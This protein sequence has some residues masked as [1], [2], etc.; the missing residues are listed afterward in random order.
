MRNDKPRRRAQGTRARPL[1]FKSRLSPF[2]VAKEFR[3]LAYRMIYAHDLM[4]KLAVDVLE[5]AESLHPWEDVFD[6]RE[7]AGWKV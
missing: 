2:Q 3:Q 6:N 7:A 5:L 4:M 1:D